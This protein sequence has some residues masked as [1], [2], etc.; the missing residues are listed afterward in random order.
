MIGYGLSLGRLSRISVENLDG[1]VEGVREQKAAEFAGFDL[2]GDG[3]TNND[4]PLFVGR[5]SLYLPA[6]KNVDLRYT[7]WIQIHGD[8]RGEI[9][10]EMKNVFNIRQLQSVNTTVVTDTAG[11]PA[12]AIPSDA[13]QFP[14]PSSASF[15]QRKFQLGFRVRF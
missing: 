11:N 12:S 8:T 10:A 9:I 4:R 15:E 1:Q 3:V 6:R 14:N 7:R 13:Y 2:N 5:N